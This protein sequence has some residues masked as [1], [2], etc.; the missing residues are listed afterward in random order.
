ML[1]GEATEEEVNTF[2]TLRKKCLS[3]QTVLQNY[4][5]SCSSNAERTRL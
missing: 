5:Q 1:V 3:L 2:G 4:L